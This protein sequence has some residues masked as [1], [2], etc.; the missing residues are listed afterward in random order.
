[1]ITLW[2]SVDD[3]KPNPKENLEW[4]KY[5]FGKEALDK[6]EKSLRE[7][8]YKKEKLMLVDWRGCIIDGNIR[9]HLAE[10]IGIKYLPIDFNFLI[11]DLNSF[12]H[13]QSYKWTEFLKLNSKEMKKAEEKLEELRA[14]LKNCT[15]QEKLKYVS[16]IIT[17]ILTQR[18]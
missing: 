15:E 13:T 3:L 16:G 1:M 7:E 11:R 5:A 9:F 6:W 10:K 4:G 12:I 17:E 2:A 8:G 18:I 14:N